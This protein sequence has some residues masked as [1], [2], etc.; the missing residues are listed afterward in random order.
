MTLALPLG[1]T[2]SAP[3]VVS[4]MGYA[5]TP[6]VTDLAL[7]HMPASNAA[8]GFEGEK[9]NHSKPQQG[10]MERAQA[11]IAQQSQGIT[12][13]LWEKSRSAALAGSALLYSSPA[14]AAS[15]EELEAFYASGLFIPS[16]ILNFFSWTHDNT[17]L[18]A[19]LSMASIL[20]AFYTDDP[21]MTAS[22]TFFF[23]ILGWIMSSD[24]D[25]DSKN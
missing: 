6:L 17:S 9:T 13:S 20:F 24:D 12:A 1:T 3:S 23:A 11:Y 19:Y 5:T 16:L 4:A 25:V 8:L 18:F 22:S 10:A 15:P 14:L 2:G 21:L 7:N